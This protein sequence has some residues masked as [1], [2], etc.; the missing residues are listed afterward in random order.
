[1]SDE[2]YIVELKPLPGFSNSPR[3]RLALALKFALRVCGLKC[4]D[5]RAKPVEPEK[6]IERY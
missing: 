3:R 1:M 2:I 5:Y 4:V 6:E